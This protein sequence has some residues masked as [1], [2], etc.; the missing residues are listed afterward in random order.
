MTLYTTSLAFQER[1]GEECIISGKIEWVVAYSRGVVTV[2]CEVVWQQDFAD[3]SRLIGSL[4]WKS[5]RMY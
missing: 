2:D 5:Q 3:I 1:L 4:L